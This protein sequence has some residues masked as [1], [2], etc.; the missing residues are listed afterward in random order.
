MSHHA[1]TIH[2]AHAKLRTREV[3]AVELT[4][5]V[6][7]RIQDTDERLHSYLTVCREEA[8]VQAEAADRILSNG[9]TPPALCG[10]PVALKDV[11][12][13][14]GIRSTAGSKILEHFI[15]PYDAT[16]T[17]R[18]KDA[19]A[20]IIG[21]VNCDEFAMG[22]SNE[23]SAFTPC[24]NPWDT[25]RVPGGSSGGS[26][27]SVAADQ[28][29]AALGTDTGGSVRLP[30]SFC[31]IVGLKPSYGRVSRFG[32][33]AYASSLDQVGP[34]TK[35]VRDCA[36]LLDVIAGYDPRDST[37]VNRPTPG[38]TTH[39]EQGVSG[40]RIGIPQQY[41]VEGMQPE[42]ETAVRDA[43]AQL[44]DLGAEVR[45]VSL[46]HTEYAVATYY[47]IAMAEASSNL[48]RYDGVRYGHRAAEVEDL[49]DLYRTTRAQGFGSEVKRRIA[50]G[51]YVLSAGYYDAYY[52]KAQK[53]RTLIRQD[54]LH[55]FNACDIIATPVAPTTAFRL[56][57]KL[58]DPLTMY[59]SDIFTIAV[60]LAGLPG[61][62]VPCGFDHQGLPIGL[63][64]IGRPFDEAIL[65]QAGYAYEQ[66][67]D[68]RTR[69]PP[70]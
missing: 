7:A 58:A 55:A 50:L 52:L 64:L 4:Q 8:L 21:K 49:G 65:L 15:P 66:D 5:S 59:L 32:V 10:I 30:A 37:S 69:K 20:V 11:I 27:T 68:W 16:V 61:L 51:T 14:Q 13:A 41:F 43:I 44:Q 12:L 40:L 28:T 17:Q 22:S 26:A 19:G 67:T 25:D 31:G 18:L 48:A 9:A 35:D 1:L 46:P 2:Q 34:C 56:G 38:Y 47:I 60:N 70:L 6:L 24:R 42:V 29:C 3:S 36:L 62:S 33:V 45:P 53:V 23:N 39:L 54:F 57:E 63:Q